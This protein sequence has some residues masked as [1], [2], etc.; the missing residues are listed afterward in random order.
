MGANNDFHWCN[1]NGVNKNDAGVVISYQEVKMNLAHRVILL[2][3]II[4][5]LKE[6][7]SSQ[8]F[9]VL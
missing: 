7:I 8:D 1:K 5:W 4:V 9:I 6:C 2:N 3:F